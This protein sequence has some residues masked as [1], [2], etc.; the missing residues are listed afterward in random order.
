METLFLRVL[1][2]SL[3][4]SYVIL[5]VLVMRFLLKW[6]PKKYSYTLWLVTAFRLVCPVSIRSVFS[7]F[8]FL[9]ERSAEAASS[10]GS[11]ITYIPSD[12]GFAAVPEV[13]T[14]IPILSDAVNRIL[15]AATPMASVNPI[16]V[17][18]FLGTVIWCVGIAV[19]LGWAVVSML[20]LRKGVEKATL[21]E[22]GIFECENVKSPFILGIFAPIIYIPHNLEPEQLRYILAHERCHIRKGDHITKFVAYC[23]LALH[24]FNPLCWLAYYLMGKDMEMRCDEHVLSRS[25]TLSWEYSYSL[26]SIATNRR[27]SPAGPLAFG[28]S[29]V[30]TRIRNILR[31]KKPKIWMS[32]LAIIVCAGCVVG[33]AMNPKLPASD[34]YTQPGQDNRL[35]LV[36]GEQIFRSGLCSTFGN[37]D[38]F[39]YF[40]DEDSICQI[41]RESGETTIDKSFER[42]WEDFPF[43]T[44]EWKDMF[45]WGVNYE[46][47]TVDF[48]A[49]RKDTRFRYINK[50]FFL[51]HLDGTMYICH[52]YKH[53]NGDPFIWDIYSLKEESGGRDAFGVEDP[54]VEFA[55]NRMAK[56]TSELAAYHDIPVTE[57]ET[58]RIER[59]PTGTVNEVL[60]IALFA[61]DYRIAVEP[62]E[63]QIPEE[64]IRQIAASNR[65]G[66]SQQ[67]YPEWLVYE[68][69][70]LV[71]S[72]QTYLLLKRHIADGTWTPMYVLTEEEIL[73]RY[74]TEELLGEYGNAYTAAAMELWLGNG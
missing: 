57:G 72:Q 70:W 36:T 53:P 54:V 2:M 56:M 5:A 33:C 48:L 68:D 15:P 61:L 58:L 41:L 65:A 21:R 20:L 37:D 45:D 18:I 17:W 74:G 71:P 60:D 42:P 9:P 43:D 62:S 67:D 44:D 35:R 64:G 7:I 25:G 10:V 4:G 32:V 16:Q 34:E 6:A 28:E 39:R 46:D 23:I 12:I 26:L 31:W 22:K 1:N 55:M 3:T 30:K 11:T 8:A 73:E 14:G 59:V 13:S 38:G 51:L 52:H 49:R 24:W 47:A 63:G 29:S 69:G 19:M 50:E 40:I 66:S 27:F